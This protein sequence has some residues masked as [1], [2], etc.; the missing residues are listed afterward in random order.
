MVYS[1]ATSQEVVK[2][3]FRNPGAASAGHLRDMGLI[4]GLGRFPGGGHSYPLQYSYLENLWTE[5]P[6]ELQPIRLQRVVHM[7]LSMQA[8]LDVFEFATLTTTSS[9]QFSHSVV[10]D[11]LRPHE[12]QH[13]WPPCP[14]PT[15]GVHPDSCP[16]SQ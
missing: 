1:F 3:I 15:P 16:S 2:A 14:S 9:V 5:E 13:A 4:S 6:G 12:S 11:S 10:S 7:R 8:F